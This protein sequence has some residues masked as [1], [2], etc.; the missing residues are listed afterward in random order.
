MSNQPKQ[1]LY[2]ESDAGGDEQVKSLSLA[3]QI[4][5]VFSEPV[6]LFKRL[7]K[8]PQ[9]VGAMLLLTALA[10]AFT[11]AWVARV[12]TLEFI[13]LQFERAQLQLSVDQLD[14]AIEMQAKLMPAFTV[15]GSLIGTPIVI[16]FSGLIYWAVGLIS[17][18]DLQWTPTYFHGL[19]VASIPTLATVPYTL[20]GTLMALLKPVGTLRSDQLV[21]S[22]LG[23]WIQ[24]DNPKLSILF[25]SLDLFL[26]IQYVMI[27][28]AAKYALRAKTWGAV[29]C[30]ILSL[31]TLCI[32]VLLAK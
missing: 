20:L 23:F 14:R 19:V 17:K 11:I 31:L 22:S 1:S 27:Y 18:E 3:D 9:W 5:G 16:F 26:L 4:S 21:P 15:L 32:S 10:L 30:V 28:F 2:G 13:T 6:E 8:K 12:D 25:S 29:L 7:S 24:P